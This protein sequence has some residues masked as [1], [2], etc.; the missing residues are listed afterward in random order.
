MP[1]TRIAPSPAHPARMKLEPYSAEIRLT[2]LTVGLDNIHYDV[3]LS[4]RFVEFTRKYLLDLVRQ[5]V[6]I[7][8]LYGKE[9]ERGRDRDRRPSGQPEHSAFRKLLTEILQESLTRAKFQQSI[10]T[11]VLHRL[12]LLKFLSQETSNQFA[13]ILVECKDWIRS[14]GELFEHSEQAHVMR[15]KI[16]EVQADR[17]NVIRQVGETLYRVWRDV[18]EGALLKTR[19]ALFGDDFREMYDL[20]QNHFLFV[21]AGNDDHFFLE[22]YILLGNFV[23]DPDRFEVFDTLLLDF[24]RDYVLSGDDDDELARARKNHERLL[25]QARLLRS[26]LARLE[27]EHDEAA[28]RA[29]DADRSFS[30]LFK[31]KPA[32]SAG[33]HHELDEVRRKIT[34]LERNLEDLEPQ[35]EAAK[36]RMDFLAEELKSRIG[37]YLNQPDNATRMFDARA[38]ENESGEDAGAPAEIRRHLLEEWVHR[39][40]ERDLLFH[41]LAGY[42]LRKIA[43]EYCPPVHLQQL[44]KAL[45]YRE[46]AKRVA[47]ILEKFPARKVSMKKLDD[48]SRAIR[49]RTVQETLTIGLQFAEDL[50]RLRRDRRNYQQVVAWMERINLVHSERARELSRAN[51][52]LYEFLHP[53]EG[54]PAEDPVI[55]H[56]VIKADVRG[57]TG[58]TKDLLARGMN[59]ASHFSMNLH[60][61][62]K[63]ML[64]RYGAAKVFIEGD[65]IILA[66]YETESTRATQRAVARACVLARE[67]LA[68]TAAYNARAKSSDLPPLELGVGVAFQDSAPS[69]WMDADSRIMISRALNLSDR[70]SSCAKMAKRLFQSNPSPFNVYLLQTLMEDVA[71]DE[72]EELLVRY[73]LNGIELNEEGF[74]KL[75]AEISLSPMSGNFPLP[76]GKERVQL[77]FGEVPLG[78]S[79]EPVVIR[80]GFVRQL[81]PGGKIGAQGTRAYYEVC[82]DAKLLEL[83]R[84]R[85]V[86]V[87]PKNA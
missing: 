16:A 58:I 14:R 33:A 17:K 79:L 83:A 71:A 76:W 8:L 85:F 22:S 31:R 32:P 30:S 6:N 25:E 66:I 41:V 77:Y 78:E 67:I 10:E 50:M 13:S 38:A 29:S 82:T 53:E 75:S 18:E 48:S 37:D 69:I 9:Q 19:R 42:E 68:V 64:E 36:Q 5:V 43:P 1:E 74:Q 15:S 26:E 57:S 54:R 52:S 65:A 59:P 80:K 70:L 73:N 28:I 24:V 2:N 62:V 45:V 11:D 60:D 27:E 56:V 87:S 7:S 47:Q 35:I 81:L 23:N 12:A 84:K 61:P 39:L 86:A 46:E 21:E 3:F 4:P 72:G 20:L 40:E 51:K 44:K 55:N 49:R 34:S 63:R